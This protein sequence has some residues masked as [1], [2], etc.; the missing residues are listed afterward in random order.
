MVIQTSTI[1]IINNSTKT[2]R[3]LNCLSFNARRI[4]NKILDLQN[5]LNTNELDLD[6]I[7]ETWLTQDITDSVINNNNSYFVFRKDR[8]GTN[9]RGVCILTRKDTIRAFA[10]KLPIALFYAEIVAIDIHNYNP[11]L[12]LSLAIAHLQPTLRRRRSNKYNCYN[13]S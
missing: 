13:L 8:L 2:L 1:T 10:A 3:Y 9:G 4:S 11:L 5:P 12:D 7:A 6:S